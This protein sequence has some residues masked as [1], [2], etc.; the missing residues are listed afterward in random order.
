[1]RT[2]SWFNIRLVC[3]VSLSISAGA[4]ARGDQT[5]SASADGRS[6]RVTSQSELRLAVSEDGLTLARM[7]RV[8]VSGAA[9]PELVRLSNGSLLALF[10]YAPPGGGEGSA[11][12]AAT[13]SRDDGVNWSP[14]QDVRIRTRDGKVQYAR[15]GSAAVMRDGSVRLFFVG[16]RRPAN[17]LA[18]ERGAVQSA[19]SRDGLN[20]Q[21]DHRARVPLAPMGRNRV[22]VLSQDNRLFLLAPVKETQ[23]DQR[24]GAS[25]RRRETALA[26]A[27][28]R[29]MR[30]FV[31]MTAWSLPVEAELVRVVERRGGFRA[32]ASGATG[33]Q[34]YDSREGTRWEPIGEVLEGV[35][36]PVF[37]P[38]RGDGFHVLYVAAMTPTGGDAGLDAPIVEYDASAALS[39]AD[40]TGEGDIDDVSG[41]VVA[42]E[43]DLALADDDGHIALADAEGSDA[44]S[45]TEAAADHHLIDVVDGWF[46]RLRDADVDGFA[47]MPDYS[48]PVDYLAWYWAFAR[49]DAPDNAFHAYMA[50]MPDPR[51]PEAQAGWPEFRDPLNDPN[52]EGPLGPWN[53][54]EHP[55]WDASNREVQELLSQF[56]DAGYSSTCSS[57]GDLGSSNEYSDE[58]GQRLLLNLV[59]PHLSAHR[60]LAKAAIADGW[61]A[62]GG[63]VS[64]SRLLGS[65]ETVLRNA[66]HVGSGVTMIEELVSVAE[67][68]LVHRSAKAALQHD[69][70]SPKELEQALDLLQ[71]FDRDDR[72]PMQSVRGEHGMAM[73]ITQY[74]FSPPGPGGEPRVNPARAADLGTTWNPDMDI[75]ERLARMKPEDAALSAETLT[76]HYREVGE[77][78]RVGYPHVRSADIAAAEA[79]NGRATPLT[80]MLVPALSRYY[81]LRTRSEASRRATQLAYATH[82][83]RAREG[84]WPES[85]SELPAEFGERM[86]IDPFSGGYFGYRVGPDGPT[87]YSVSEN[88]V[89]DGGVHSRRWND[90]APTGSDDHVL[91]PPQD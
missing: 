21:L 8:F 39:I 5:R 69:V 3:A 32:W 82:L 17:G 83:F 81:Q 56:R 86:R 79:R 41:E 52:H 91:W 54:A 65:W 28:S 60:T 67:R 23:E 34:A 47:P 31:S 53:P 33:T 59:L 19:I 2:R 73:D 46:E 14:L 7:G 9:A 89:D 25:E 40:G 13:L 29:D 12:L 20:W 15:R 22:S 57:P 62:D 85:L 11:R 36:D 51:D 37:L 74:L 44:D 61:R 78:M 77:L 49:V 66:N 43:E 38:R 84:R 30:R 35:R 18:N 10:D 58:A 55:E 4:D 87:I 24:A 42:P 90:N 68:N 76:A 45:T 71:R 70:L 6:D 80:E 72:D 1:M 26:R 16:A 88:G 27:M 75:K 48:R 50:F 63:R 64:P